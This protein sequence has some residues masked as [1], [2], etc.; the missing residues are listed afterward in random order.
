MGYTTEKSEA[1]WECEKRASIIKIL[2]HE[3]KVGMA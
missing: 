1:G 3:A 2:G